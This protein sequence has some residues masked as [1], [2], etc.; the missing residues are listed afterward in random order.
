MPLTI[1]DCDDWRE[2]MQLIVDYINTFEVTPYDA[3]CGIDEAELA[4]GN[5]VVKVDGVSITC[6]AGTGELEVTAAGANTLVFENANVA[7]GT[8]GVL[9]STS[10]FLVFTDNG[11]A[12][13][14]DVGLVTTEIQILAIKSGGAHTLA[15]S[16]NNLVLTLKTTLHT[17]RVFSHSSAD[18]TDQTVTY[19]GATVC[20]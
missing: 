20:P 9:N 7:A 16:G 1:N 13:Q 17:L 6:N 12:S 2:S 18:G 14:M 8:R 15:M 10:S 5:L 3:G 19:T 11:G 4:L